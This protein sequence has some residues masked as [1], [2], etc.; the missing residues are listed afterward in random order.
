MK[1][2]LL[3]PFLCL[4]FVFALP[5][6]AQDEDTESETSAETSTGTAPSIVSL[7]PDTLIISGGGRG[8]VDVEYED[9]EGDATR[10]IWEVF[11]AAEDTSWNLPDGVFVQETVGTT[12]P[13]T[14]RCD[15]TDAA[16]SIQL[17]IEDAQGN[18]SEPEFLLL[19]CQ[20][21]VEEDDGQ[22]GGATPGSAPEILTVTPSRIVI[23]G[24]GTATTEIEYSDEDGDASAFLWSIVDA[25]DET[26]WSL[27]NGFFSQ[28][29]VGTTIPV[30]F[31]CLAGEETQTLEME[32]IVQDA[33]GN[34]SE[35]STL[36]LVCS[37]GEDE[38][39]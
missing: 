35:P 2:S 32:V 17:I 11:E 9:A 7:S 36:T 15:N 18:Q 22:G 38:E 24:T 16:V 4:L 20:T 26:D 23:E 21:A 6:A 3:I 5:L 14:F 29:I 8:T 27:E 31:R 33:E 39:E 28:E 25:E 1:K 30:T 34:Q 10:F 19:E 12:I 37:T 13:V